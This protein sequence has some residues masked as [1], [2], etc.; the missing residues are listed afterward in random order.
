MY[1]MLNTSYITMSEV[2]NECVIAYPLEKR[3]ELYYLNQQMKPENQFQPSNDE[4]SFSIAKTLYCL[5]L[6]KKCNLC[7]MCKHFVKLGLNRFGQRV[8]ED[9]SECGFIVET[10]RVM[11]R[12]F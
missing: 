5:Y 1:E 8:Y 10:I 2:L 12:I 9:R 7:G 11:V 6:R 4:S 3:K